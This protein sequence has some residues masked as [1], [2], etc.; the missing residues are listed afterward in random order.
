MKMSWRGVTGCCKI[1]CF[2]QLRTYQESKTYLSRWFC[3]SHIDII[4]EIMVPLSFPC[5]CLYIPIVI[6][7][8]IYKSMWC[9]WIERFVHCDGRRPLD[10]EFMKGPRWTCDPVKGFSLF[11]STF[12][13]I[14]RMANGTDNIP[15]APTQSK[16]SVAPFLL[17]G[18]CPVD[19]LRNNV[20]LRADPIIIPDW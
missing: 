1:D 9:Y 12:V 2:L 3:R 14:P 17:L 11:T 8:N 13:C 19:I 15:P 4:C 16:K 6:A 20:A 5:T 18:T 7:A 10:P